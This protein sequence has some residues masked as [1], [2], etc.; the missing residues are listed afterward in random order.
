V[1][2]DSGELGKYTSVYFK[3]FFRGRSVER[4]HLHG[5]DLKSFLKDAINYFSSKSCGNDVRL[6]NSAGT[7]GEVGGR[8]LAHE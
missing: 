4:E 8:R 3:E 5:R 6:N 1:L 7:V 2:G